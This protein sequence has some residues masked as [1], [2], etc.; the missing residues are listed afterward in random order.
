MVILRRN[1]IHTS[2][3]NVANIY[4]TAVKYTAF[5]RWIYVWKVVL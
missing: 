4:S 1:D 2:D 3:C 5:M